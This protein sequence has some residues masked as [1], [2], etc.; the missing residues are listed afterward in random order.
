MEEL[1][2]SINLSTLGMARVLGYSQEQVLRDCTIRELLLYLGL[3]PTPAPI[4]EP[5][6]PEPKY[7]DVD[8]FISSVR[9]GLGGY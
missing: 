3:L 8:S 5:V 4:P 6:K 2:A 9:T 7:D 1:I